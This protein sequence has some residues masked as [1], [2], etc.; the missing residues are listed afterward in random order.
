[1]SKFTIIKRAAI[2]KISIARLNINDILRKRD[3]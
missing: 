2:V 1:M 3:H